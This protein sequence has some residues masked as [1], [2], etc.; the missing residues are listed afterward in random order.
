MLKKLFWGF[1]FGAIGLGMFIYGT[2][3]SLAA[4][5]FTLNIGH[6]LTRSTRSRSV[7]CGSRR[8]QPRRAGA[9]Q[10]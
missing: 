9:D 6:V 7:G 3:P 2:T 10:G 1:V 5:Q 4:E 8:Q